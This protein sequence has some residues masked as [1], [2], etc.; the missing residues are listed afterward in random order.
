M[1]KLT[2]ETLLQYYISWNKNF[3][4]EKYNEFLELIENGKEYMV[5]ID[6]GLIYP[7]WFYEE[8]LKG[9]LK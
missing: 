8:M 6:Q 4:I 3:T 1:N 2:K 5:N 9:E 7:Q